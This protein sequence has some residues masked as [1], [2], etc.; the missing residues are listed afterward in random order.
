M[1]GVC[2]VFHASSRAPAKGKMATP[3]ASAQPSLRL[4]Q[5]ASSALPAELQDEVGR[6]FSRSEGCRVTRSWHWR[7]LNTETLEHWRPEGLSA[8]AQQA[9]QTEAAAAPQASPAKGRSAAGRSA[10]SGKLLALPANL[11]PPSAGA[12]HAHGSAKLGRPG[13]GIALKPSWPQLVACAGNP[14]GQAQKKNLH[15]GL[16]NFWLAGQKF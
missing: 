13:W 8:P 15:D 4:F 6:C 7:R 5:G 16:L 2:G 12:R 3:P 14:A 1:C 11:L 10:P 9:S